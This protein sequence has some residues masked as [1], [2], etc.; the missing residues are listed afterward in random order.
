MPAISEYE[1]NSA[2]HALY[3]RVSL[4][5]HTTDYIFNKYVAHTARETAV[6]LEQRLQRADAMMCDSCWQEHPSVMALCL[7]GW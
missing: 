4:H 1:S 3:T 2:T 6:E 7:R 5:F